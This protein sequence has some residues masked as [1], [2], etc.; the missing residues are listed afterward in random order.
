MSLKTYYVTFG[1][2]YAHENHEYFPSAHPDGWVEII[3]SSLASARRIAH[4][5]LGNRW[6]F[7]YTE[8]TIKSEYFPRGCLAQFYEPSDAERLRF[9]MQDIDAVEGV[10]FDRYDLAS[11][12]AAG[13]KH[14]EPDADDEL[15]GF[16]LLLDYAIA[17]KP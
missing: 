4:W 5:H 6:A 16:R 12:I 14:S 2:K 9:L 1:S 10:R 13:N 3:A 7:I 15:D 17:N 8:E 11:E